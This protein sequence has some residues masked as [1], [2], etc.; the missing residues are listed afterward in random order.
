V[1]TKAAS[2]NKEALIPQSVQLFGALTSAVILASAIGSYAYTSAGDENNLKYKAYKKA[3]KEY[4]KNK[5]GIT[6]IT[7]A[8]KD[9]P[10]YFAAIDAAGQK[11]APTVRQQPSYDADALNKP[12][13]ISI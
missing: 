2:Q 7:V 5:S 10:S 11:Q 3:L 6:P 13:S 4:A 8:P 9:A 12:I 1:Y